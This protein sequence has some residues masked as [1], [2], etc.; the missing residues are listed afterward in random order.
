MGFQKVFN[1]AGFRKAA[2]DA[3]MKLLF[4]FL[5]EATGKH[6]DGFLTFNEFALMKG[7]QSRALTGNP[8]RLR[9]ILEEHGGFDA[10]FKRMHTSWLRRALINGLRQTAVRGLGR[11][12]ANG[13]KSSTQSRDAALSAR[14]SQIGRA[15]SSGGRLDPTRPGLQ[16]H[17]AKSQASL[18]PLN[19]TR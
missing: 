4:L 13:M 2:P 18:P 19:R 8:A 16:L 1:Q 15:T 5:D 11:A 17:K 12:F 7:F 3:D 10:A 6:A 14:G 9:R